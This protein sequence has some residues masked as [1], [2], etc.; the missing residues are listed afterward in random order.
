MKNLVTVIITTYNRLD[1]LK[2]ALSSVLNQ[3]YKNIEII[4]VDSS[5]NAETQD[6]ITEN[7]HLIYIHSD[8]NHPN[9]LRNLG[10]QCA[11]G[12]YIAFLDDDDTWKSS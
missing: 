7:K 8:I 4:I 9:V 12:N 6:F 5:N 11:N 10:I 3:S 1:F 2:D